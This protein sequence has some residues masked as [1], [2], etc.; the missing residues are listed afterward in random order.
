MDPWTDRRIR[1]IMAA[2]KHGHALA[3]GTL[4]LALAA[5]GGHD[6]K[7]TTAPTTDPTTTT[8]GATPDFRIEAVINNVTV[9]AGPGAGTTFDP[10]PGYRFQD[11]RNIELRDSLTFQLVYY[12]GS[13]ASLVRN[14]VGAVA[15]GGTDNSVSFTTNDSRGAAGSLTPTDGSF[16]ASS[17]AVG[18][19]T[20]TGTYSGLNYSTTYVVNPR[21]IRV[22]GAVVVNVG[23]A[24][25]PAYQGVYGA[26]VDFYAAR[27]SQ[28]AGR[29]VIV[30]TVHTAE[31]GTFRASV[32]VPIDVAVPTPD[33]PSNTLPND[34]RFVVRP[35][36]G[37]GTTF[38][39]QGADYTPESS[40]TSAQI[41]NG[42]PTLSSI[43]APNGSY[44]T[45]D[46]YLIP[47]NDIVPATESTFTL[48]N[49]D[50]AANLIVIAPDTASSSLRTRSTTKKAH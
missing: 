28:S 22:H 34:I 39:F 12:T 36:N 38:T 30:Q 44:A 3:I 46:F 48:S 25:A 9:S 8:P 26:E 50:D 27:S 47:G 32:P 35:P 1:G 41:V 18:P 24:D 7:T 20:V 31:D 10:D 29:Q 43:L 11:T 17:N 16:A 37:F 19:Y 23:T 14:V 6:H 21:Q 2:M 33:D 42:F 13:G 40:P 45:G 4:A 5:C 49:P 15:G